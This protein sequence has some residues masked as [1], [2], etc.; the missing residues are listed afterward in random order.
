MPV[1]SRTR[2]RA[3]RGS[4]LVMRANAPAGGMPA[5]DP[6]VTFRHASGWIST[7]GSSRHALEGISCEKSN[8]SYCWFVLE[9]KLDPRFWMSV[10]IFANHLHVGSLLAALK[11]DLVSHWISLPRVVQK[12]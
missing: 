4:F 8:D 12:V 6:N 3:A 5:V 1:P 10:S 11:A 7:F 2:P 9:A